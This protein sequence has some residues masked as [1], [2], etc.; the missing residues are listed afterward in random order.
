[1]ENNDN[2]ARVLATY[3]PGAVARRLASNPAPIQVPDMEHASGVCLFLDI[4][5]FTPL[6]ERLAR[7]G[8]AGAEQMAG[9]LNKT[10]GPVV[11]ACTEHGGEIIDFAGDALLVIWWAK[12]DAMADAAA[13][14]TQCA[15]KLQTVVGQ[16]SVEGSINISVKITLTCGSLQVL[17]VG[18]VG[19]KK[20]SLVVGPPIERL[21]PMDD[22][23]EAGLVVAGPEVAALLGDRYQGPTTATGNVRID[24][25]QT[26]ILPRAIERPSIDGTAETALKEYVPEIIPARLGAGQDEWLAEYRRL[27][28]V[29]V[30]LIGLRFEDPAGP[31][32]FHEVIRAIQLV[33]QRFGGSIHQ[34]MDGDKGMVLLAA[35]GLPPH[36][37]EDDPSRGVMAALD[38]EEVVAEHGLRSA[39]GITTGKAFTGPIG[40]ERRREYAVVGDVVNLGARL[41]QAASDDILCDSATTHSYPA[42]EYE[43]I[44]PL[45]VKG[46]LDA[47]PVFRPHG[48]APRILDRSGSDTPIVG[49]VAEQKALADLLEAIA[50]DGPGAVVVVEGEAGIGKSRLLRHMAGRADSQGIRVL[51]GSGS[52]IEEATPYLG[53][54]PVLVDALDLDGTAA[55]AGARRRH[56]LRWFGSGSI[57]LEDAPLLNDVIGL[58]LPESEEISR[59]PDEV[60]AERARNLLVNIMA[61]AVGAEPALIVL[62][63]GHHLDSAS[64][65]LVAAVRDRLPQSIVALGL[66]PPATPPDARRAD[67]IDASIHL[68]LGKLAP[69]ETVELVERSLGV[70]VGHLP[71]AVRDLIAARTA[72]HPFFSQ[73]LAFAL[74][75]E[76][77]ITVKDGFCRLVASVE[78]LGR[79]TIPNTVQGVVTSRIDRLPAATQLLLKTASVVGYSF[80]ADVLADVHPTGAE[81]LEIKTGLDDLEMR[82]FI[83]SDGRPTQTYRFQH[84]IFRDVAYEALAYSQRRRLHRAVAGSLESRGDDAGAALLGH[85]WFQAAGEGSDAGDALSN[86]ERYLLQAGRLALRQGA[87]TEAEKALRTALSCHDRLAADLQDRERGIDILQHLSTATFATSG[88]GSARTR[89][90]TQRAY[91]AARD[92]VGGPELFPI[93]WSLWI[94]NHFSFATDTAVSMGEELM[95]IAQA[96]NDDELRMQA[97][98]ALWTTLIQVPDYR[99]AQRHLDEGT[100]LYRPEWHVRHCAEFGGHDPGSCAQ[101]ALGLTLWTTGQ[102]DRA[103]QAG[104]QAVQLAQ[105]HAFSAMSARLALAFIHHERGDLDATQTEARALID[106]AT[107]AGLP[108]NI[109]WASILIAWAEGR[110]GNP[111]PAIDEITEIKD[112]LGMKDPGYLAMLVELLIAD[113]RSQESLALIDELLAVVDA[114]QHRQYEAELH[115]LRGEALR[116]DDSTRNAAEESMRRSVAVAKA[117]GALSF[118]LRAHMS[119][120]KL[121]AGTDLAEES[122]GELAATLARFGEG[123]GTSDLIAAQALIAVR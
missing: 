109:D 29:F 76:G 115:R 92:R 104:Q 34:L 86:A 45:T 49:R 78:E 84:A 4:T 52:A 107:D 22:D 116:L 42:I 7:L 118:E 33:V 87:F 96:E 44:D 8:S 90:V 63:D 119:L 85:H 13:R 58:E 17:H 71:E 14:A 121:L 95:A 75:D 21:G 41:M 26:S 10:F 83:S 64:W 27:T 81:S 31:N 70:G 101:R 23:A 65:S 97:H 100:R 38:I 1:M 56:V 35:F 68:V 82:S 93:L 57:P 50:R 47:V 103:V 15:L 67:I 5:G 16:Q 60:R 36:A 39:I 105:D 24:E 12:T 110:R 114:K 69:D 32:R 98:H 79:L 80:D 91:E 43:P 3:V 120:A 40:G 62:E 111:S 20:H 18:G 117:Q 11:D 108:A 113:G 102:S 73:E 99:R 30:N 28:S 72:G 2:L 55:N 37:H 74:R 94:S 51:A 77:I 122:V 88:Y 46:K 6:T 19:G 61:A 53:W 54:R 89:E 66:R 112:R 25:L 48:D 123:F 106:V 9:I 59:L